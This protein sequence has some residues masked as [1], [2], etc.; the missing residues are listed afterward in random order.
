V[1]SFHSSILPLEI[2]VSAVIGV[3]KNLGALGSGYGP[4]A[5]IAID[6]FMSKFD[7]FVDVGIEIHPGNPHIFQ[8]QRNAE[9]GQEGSDTAN[10][11]YQTILGIFGLDIQSFADKEVL[12]RNFAAELEGVGNEK[13]YGQPVVQVEC[14]TQGMT[15]TVGQV[16]AAHAEG[17]SG[18]T[19]GQEHSVSRFPIL[20]VLIRPR[21][22][23]KGHLNS[24]E[25]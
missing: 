22:P 24:I 19:R 7:Q 4:G 11:F 2:D 10:Q 18:D 15:E 5:E 8:G 1:I 6:V 3:L 25:S 14:R 13:T 16:T 9:L 20:S 23:L 12:I 21:E 17:D